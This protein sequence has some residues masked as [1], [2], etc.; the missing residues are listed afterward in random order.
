MI[1]NMNTNHDYDS[2]AS[3][4]STFEQIF[5]DELR[6]LNEMAHLE[7]MYVDNYVSMPIVTSNQGFKDLFLRSSEEP[8]QFA[9]LTLVQSR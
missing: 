6:F 7:L 9:F 2:I 8:Q 4:E 1:Q 5:E 3:L